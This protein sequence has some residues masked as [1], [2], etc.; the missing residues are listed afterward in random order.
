[1][2]VVASGGGGGGRR[3]PEVVA[4]GGG[5]RRWPTV[6]AGGGGRWW[7]P[8]AVAGGGG[9]RRWPA[10]VAGGG[11]RWCSAVAGGGGRRWPEVVAGSGGR[12]WWPEV[13]TGGGRRWWPAVVAGCGDRR[14][15]FSLRR[16]RVDILQSPF[17]D[18]TFGND[19]TAD[20]YIDRIIY[21]LTLA[22]EDQI[23]QGRWY[24]I[25]R[26]ST[27]PD[28]DPTPATT[29]RGILLPTI[30][31]LIVACFN[32]LIINRLNSIPGFTSKP[33]SDDLKARLSRNILCKFFFYAVISM[34]IFKTFSNCQLRDIQNFQA[35]INYCSIKYKLFIN[36]MQWAILRRARMTKFE[37]HGLKKGLE[38]GKNSADLSRSGTSI[39]SYQKK[40][41]KQDMK[42][43][44]PQLVLSLGAD[45]LVLSLLRSNFPL[46]EELFSSS[47][48]TCRGELSSQGNRGEEN[49][50]TS[51]SCFSCFSSA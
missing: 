23:P 4:G 45:E 16:A 19:R 27:S 43:S 21:Q 35:E 18:V 9:R 32:N 1:M 28:L 47:E 39:S 48:T 51:G 17:F 7:W 25:S 29:T 2:K 37:T 30:A 31:L 11:R 5:R 36:C 44:S 33:S 15:E 38:T 40:L 22:I 42:E 41:L 20:E 26:P 3:W 24:I 8:K 10:V 50:K 49:F 14:A 12:R 6:V 13:V 34:I 46:N